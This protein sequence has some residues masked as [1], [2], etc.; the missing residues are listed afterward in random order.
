MVIDRPEVER[1]DTI[2]Q[3]RPQVLRD[4]YVAV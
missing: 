3:I 4:D 1:L 2:E